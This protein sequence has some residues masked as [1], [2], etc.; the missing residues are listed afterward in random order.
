MKW[1]KPNYFIIF[2]GFV[3]SA[4]LNAQARLAPTND[5]NAMARSGQSEIIINAEN[6]DRDVVVWINGAIVAHL[7]PKTKEKIIVFN[8]H[9]I[10]EAADTTLNRQGQWIIGAKRQIT[11]NSNSNAV[12]V[13][14][15]ARYNALIR[16]EILN[17]IALRGG[18]SQPPQPPVQGNP[19]IDAAVQRAAAMMIDDIPADS[20]VA[21]MGI[22]AADPYLA[23][24][25]V[26]DLEYFLWGARRFT[27][28]DRTT[29]DT[30]RAETR[31]QYSGEVDDNKAVD[32]GKM[33]GA[34]IV[35][36]GSV[37][38]TGS[39]RRLMTRAMDVQS[40]IVVALASVG[41]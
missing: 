20:I 32:L 10:V 18:G 35:V 33:V 41:F 29:L 34:T 1:I 24:I 15:A 30:I 6:V 25:I 23:A 7:Y 31:F 26:G 8:G 38:E 13:G 2:L 27:L 17:T 4:N 11:V 39:I 36:T 37:N 14:M 28:V 19:T 21:V 40:G 3:L 22:T 5:P 12:T 16:L 9:N